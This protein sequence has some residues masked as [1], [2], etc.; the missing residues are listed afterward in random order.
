MCTECGVKNTNEPSS[1]QFFVRDFLKIIWINYVIYYDS[2]MNIYICWPIFY[3][4]PPW[5]HIVIASWIKQLPSNR[6]VVNIDKL[7]T[8]KT[9]YGHVAT[10]LQREMDNT[11]WKDFRHK[12]ELT[13]TFW[14]L[15]PVN[16]IHWVS[17][18]GAENSIY[19]YYSWHLR[20]HS[21]KNLDCGLRHNSHAGG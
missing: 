12:I 6:T 21:D 8:M 11:G 19:W 17:F 20:S 7:C 14:F 18:Y 1:Y 10:R 9:S 15:G 5:H 4:L 3:Y 16:C 2:V 13:S